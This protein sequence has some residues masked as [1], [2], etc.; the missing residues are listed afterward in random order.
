MKWQ[1]PQQRPDSY[2]GG[3]DQQE[4]QVETTAEW[5]KVTGNQRRDMKLSA[6]VLWQQRGTKYGMV[7]AGVP[8][9]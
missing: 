9:L 4:S 5:V 6:D 7:Q 2:R 1:Q 8:R 3:V